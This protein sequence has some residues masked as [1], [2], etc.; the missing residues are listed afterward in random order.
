[1]IQTNVGANNNKFY[2]IQL[3]QSDSNANQFYVWNR[4][5]RVGVRGQMRLFGPMDLSGAKALLRHHPADL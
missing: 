4:W 2:I 5:G 1:M 3:L